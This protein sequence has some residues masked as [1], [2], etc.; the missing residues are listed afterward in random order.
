MTQFAEQM[1]P[2]KTAS[3]HWHR[4]LFW[5]GFIGSAVLTCALLLD[6][7]VVQPAALQAAEANAQPVAAG[8]LRQLPVVT[9]GQPEH[10]ALPHIYRVNLR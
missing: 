5:L 3:P 7:W 4:L 2:R 9:A 8:A 10:A 1:A 6:A